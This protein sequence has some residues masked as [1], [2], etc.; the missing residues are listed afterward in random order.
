MTQKEQRRQLSVKRFTNAKILANAEG[1]EHLTVYKKH[2]DFIVYE[3]YTDMFK[4]LKPIYIVVE[5][6]DNVPYLALKSVVDAM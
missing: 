1:Y 6:Y 3:A 2:K 4:I 5:Y